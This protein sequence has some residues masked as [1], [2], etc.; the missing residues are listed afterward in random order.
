ML[1]NYKILI[2]TIIFL[3]LF[4][5]IFK[6]KNENTQYIEEIGNYKLTISEQR[7]TIDVLSS[8]NIA[9]EEQKKSNLIS[10]NTLQKQLNSIKTHN[11]NTLK[12]L[13]QLYM[14]ALEDA[15][16]NCSNKKDSIPTETSSKQVNTLN[17]KF[18][19]MRNNVYNN[20]IWK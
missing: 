20:Y 9:L 5:Y 4:A 6:I 8:K 15:N 12:N 16:E 18:L 2:V 3:L 1:S 11:Q 17:E 10:I 13:E 14:S 19:N 7:K